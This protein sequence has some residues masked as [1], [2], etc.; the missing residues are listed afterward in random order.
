MKHEAPNEFDTF[1]DTIDRLL[2]V[3]HSEIQKREQEYRKKVASNPHKRGPKR[4]AKSSASRDVD[5]A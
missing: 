2:S 5:G 1:T 3:P 4:K